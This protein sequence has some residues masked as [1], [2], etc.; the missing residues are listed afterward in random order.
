MLVYKN[1]T[2]ETTT[3]LITKGGSVTKR[4]SSILISNNS[5]NNATGVCVDLYDGTNVFYFIRDIVI[6]TQVSLLLEDYVSFDSEKYNL[7][8]SNA[9]TNPNLTVIIN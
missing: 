3:T 7:R 9:G 8:I 1:I 5:S 2:S 4:I 6:P